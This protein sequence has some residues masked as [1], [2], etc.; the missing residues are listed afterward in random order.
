MHLYT[1]LIGATKSETVNIKW[2]MTSN[3]D[4]NVHDDQISIAEQQT[5]SH[6]DAVGQTVSLSLI[7]SIKEAVKIAYPHPVY[8]NHAEVPFTYEI[9]QFK[10]WDDIVLPLAHAWIEVG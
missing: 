5:S 7:N 4:A 3:I 2:Q 1:T 6:R 8:K 10:G 9:L